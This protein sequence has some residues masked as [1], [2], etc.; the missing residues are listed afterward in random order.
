[1]MKN[2]LAIS[3]ALLMM[4]GA[5]AETAQ[6]K[7]PL[8]ASV[9]PCEGMQIKGFG[10]AEAKHG[11]PKQLTTLYNTPK[12]EM[13]HYAT[14]VSMH[15]FMS[16]VHF[17]GLAN[18][19]CVE[20]NE[21]YIGTLSPMSVAG[22]FWVKGTIDEQG[23]I[24]ILPQPVLNSNLGYLD[25]NYTFGIAKLVLSEPDENNQVSVIGIDQ[26]GIKMHMDEQGVI[27]S[28]DPRAYIALIFSDEQGQP[29]LSSKGNIQVEDYSYGFNLYPVLR[30]AAVLPEGAELTPYN[31]T[32]RKSNNVEYSGLGGIYTEGDVAYVSG[33]IAEMPEY[34]VKGNLSDGK[35]VIP[36]GQLLGDVHNEDYEILGYYGN[37]VHCF[38]GFELTGEV[39]AEGYSLTRQA[40]NIVLNATDDDQFALSE[41][42]YITDA[43]PGGHIYEYYWNMNL[44]KF[45]EDIIP[46][47]VAPH[48]INLNN[49]TSK[50]GTTT[51]Q[52]VFF[53]YNKSVDGE[54]IDPNQ[55]SYRVFF[56]DYLYEFAA[57]QYPGQG[58]L[59]G[60]TEIPW[61]GD[62]ENV[63]YYEVFGMKAHI[64]F[65]FDDLFNTMGIQGINTVGD[66]RTYS[67][68]AVVDH[69]GA[70]LP[71]V[72]GSG[73]TQVAPDHAN[74][75]TY[76]DIQGHKIDAPKAGSFSIARMVMPDGK[77]RS[78]KVKM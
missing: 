49:M 70:R 75:V 55:L 18:D 54:Y 74:E 50:Y 35:I 67:D 76:Y 17:D 13:M 56:D 4:A 58:E 66:S 60:T 7:M 16:F 10:H 69:N 72:P 19:V 45:R 2:F 20:G 15:T 33:L 12:G 65:F 39:D 1:M 59:A 36:T 40:E 31:V 43:A 38:D 8:A 57:D 23:D 28:L 46:V 44:G 34:Y 53:W 9:T 37:F 61:Y 51:F 24:T 73:I 21:I 64:F 26:E 68:I 22:N 42:Q 77:V 71:D 30:P 62:W 52:V 78:F 27:T 6:V 14:S 11:Q 25:Q 63:Y 47:P 41:T 5:Q 3:A 32:Y 48:E 29:V